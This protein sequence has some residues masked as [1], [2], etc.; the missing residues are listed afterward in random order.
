MSEH[1]PVPRSGEGVDDAHARVRGRYLA[2][3]HGLRDGVAKAVAYRELGWTASPIARKLDVGESTVRG[4]LD[5]IAGRFGERATETKWEEQR[6][7]P[8]GERGG[9][10]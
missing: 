4:W 9:S 3:R 8:L 2:S 6:T 1:A 10:R 5:D 7:G